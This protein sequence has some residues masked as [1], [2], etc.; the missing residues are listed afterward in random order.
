MSESIG[1]LKLILEQKEMKLKSG[2]YCDT[3]LDMTYHT[4]KIEG[5]TLTL[6]QTQNIY[7]FNKISGA[8]DIDDIIETKNLFQMFDYML[9]NCQKKLSIEEIKEYHKILKTGTEDSKKDW[10]NVG[11]YKRLQNSVGMLVTA[12]P[13]EVEDKMDELLITYNAKKT[14]RL[15]DITDFHYRFEIIHPFQDGNGRVGRNIMF[16]ECLRNGVMPFIITEDMK[17]E[18]VRGLQ[19]YER[20]PEI[21]LEVCRQ[22]QAE[23]ERKAFA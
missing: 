19:E 3:L 6:E 14:I 8:A 4:N 15:E 10:F 13:D 22:A 1:I 21:L 11:D 12:S 7:A 5:S 16:R 9:D 17:F 18:Y 2:L 23:Y 20:N